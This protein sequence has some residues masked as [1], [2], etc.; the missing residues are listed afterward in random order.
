MGIFSN[1]K[2]STASFDNFTK[3]IEK[4]IRENPED[5]RMDFDLENKKILI[6]INPEY[7]W[8]NMGRIGLSR[9]IPQDSK[10]RKRNIELVG[11]WLLSILSKK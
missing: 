4:S 10:N 2:E 3:A 6:S 7:G 1:K 9:L 11:E 8:I 5:W